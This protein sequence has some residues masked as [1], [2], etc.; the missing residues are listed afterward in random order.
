MVVV[1]GL[2]MI[3]SSFVGGVLTPR[4]GGGKVVIVSMVMC[5]VFPTVLVFTSSTWMGLLVM[6]AI[7]WAGNFYV[8]PVFA[9]VP[10]SVSREH[11][12]T[13]FGIFNMASFIGS[14]ITPIFVGYVL[15][16]LGRYDIGFVAISMIAVSG[17]IGSL[18]FAR[19]KPAYQ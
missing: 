13:A 12:G 14:S 8:P 7:G 3:I 15:D 16:T 9:R 6:A 11:S 19:R 5:V 17:L 10:L 2:M 4:V 18:F 1:L